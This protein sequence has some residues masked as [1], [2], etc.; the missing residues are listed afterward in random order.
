MVV[1]NDRVLVQFLQKHLKTFSFLDDAA[2]TNLE[3][4]LFDKLANWP[5]P[6]LKKFYRSSTRSLHV[7]EN[8]FRLDTMSLYGFSIKNALEPED[9][10]ELWRS[11]LSSALMSLKAKDKEDIGDLEK[12]R[13]ETYGTQDYGLD[14]LV[15]YFR[16]FSKFERLLYGSNKYYRDHFYHLFNVWLLGSYFLKSYFKK[17]GSYNLYLDCNDTSSKKIK[18]SEIEIDSMWCLIA[19]THDLGYTLEKFSNINKLVKDIMPSFGNITFQELQYSLPLQNQYSY[20]YLLKFL[21]SRLTL[22]GRNKR[23]STHLQSKYYIKFLNSF[24]N[25]DHGIMSCVLLMR[26][27]VFFLESDFAYSNP[28]GPHFKLRDAK[29][30]QIRREILRAIAAHTCENVYHLR[31]NTLPFLLIAC[32]EMQDW[33]RPRLDDIITTQSNSYTQI[34]YDCFSADNISYTISLWSDAKQ[35]DIETEWKHRIDRYKKLFRTALE[36]KK[37]KFTFS[38]KLKFHQKFTNKT[39]LQKQFT[40]SQNEFSES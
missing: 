5:K 32:D 35:K 31:L 15:G 18:L 17:G 19:L 14:K 26:H 30:F 23:Y 1:L 20:D 40:F 9:F 36:W 33:G 8:N 13:N 25:L 28:S 24:E 16:A 21:S 22:L 38:I 7:N 34:K 12:V 37:R 3:S 2:K 10:I 27:L 4:L 6:P 11:L 39:T 29:Q